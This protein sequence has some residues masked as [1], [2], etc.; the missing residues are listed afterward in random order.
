MSKGS[1]RQ[2]RPPK[3]SVGSRSLNRRRESRRPREE[4]SSVDEVARGAPSRRSMHVGAALRRVPTLAWMCALI[5]FLNAS[6]WALIVPPFQGKDETDHF[7]YVEQ[8]AENGT[9]PEGSGYTGRY[10][11][12]EALVLQAL[13]YNEVR[14]SPATPAI[15]SLGEQQTLNEALGAGA[16]LQGPG[17]A[18]I[19]STEP[20]LYYAIQTIPY[21]LARGNI[22]DQL[23]LMRLVGALFGA[24][25]ALL[26]FL[27]LR[28]ILPGAPWAATI[29]ALCVA[30]QPAF[31]FVSGSVNPDSMLFTVAA[32]V[33]LCLARAFHRGLTRRRAVVLGILIAVGFLTKLNFIGFAAGVYVGLIVLA[34]RGV[35][36]QGRE[37]MLSPTIA[38]GI[39]VSPAILYV[40]RNLLANHHTLGAV[41]GGHSLLSAKSLFHALS[42]IWQLYLPRLPGMPHYFAGL[43]T[44]KDVWFDR[45]VGLYG[46]STRCSRRGSATWR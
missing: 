2:P 42:Y 32:G 22:L 40:L 16:S 31:A 37:G 23:Q 12:Q 11:L 9:L 20:P 26:T 36:D 38:A 45:S 41:S 28:E 15:S 27:F 25:T 10:S 4:R 35:K 14:H 7:A 17:N 29:G 44:Y 19:A 30:L 34:V 3:A 39:G 6:A 33:F 5:A 43:M 21:A 1:V 24:L 13:H 8:L 18:G 46:W